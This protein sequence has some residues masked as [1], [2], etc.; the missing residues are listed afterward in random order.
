MEIMAKK[1]IP[2]LDQQKVQADLLAYLNGFPA[3]IDVFL[4][5]FDELLESVRAAILGVIMDTI[6]EM[7]DPGQ[8]GKTVTENVIEKSKGLRRNKGLKKK[9]DREMD[10]Y[11]EQVTGM[12]R[13][14]QARAYRAA[15]RAIARI[16]TSNTPDGITLAASVTQREL[17][18]VYDYP[19][20]GESLD[21]WITDFR[22]ILRQRLYRAMSLRVAPEKGTQDGRGLLR[23]RVGMAIDETN[24]KLRSLASVAL[25]HANAIAYESEGAIFAKDAEWKINA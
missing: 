8:P 13:R 9:L 19:L 18:T 16:W 6:D 21:D 25:N 11:K 3:E 10:N 2:K 12:I 1:Q 15:Q 17:R 23:K 4:K 5:P 24:K 22:Q 14:L 7:K 20:G